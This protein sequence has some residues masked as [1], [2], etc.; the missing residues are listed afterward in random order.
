MKWTLIFT[1]PAIPCQSKATI[2]S[3]GTFSRAFC[4]CQEPLR[5][6]PHHRAA[7]LEYVPSKFCTS[8]LRRVETCMNSLVFVRKTLKKYEKLSK[9]SYFMKCYHLDWNGKHEDFRCRIGPVLLGFCSRTLSV[10]AVSQA[11]QSGERRG[12]LP[13]PRNRS[14][15]LHWK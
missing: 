3:I 9:C 11:K 5:I 8:E 2:E 14:V 12:T 4:C 15:P 7:P 13:G 1:W 6:P 10:V